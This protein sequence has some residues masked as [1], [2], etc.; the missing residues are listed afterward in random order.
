MKNWTLSGNSRTCGAW[1]RKH[2]ALSLPPGDAKNASSAARKAGEWIDRDKGEVSH[3]S[4]TRSW[5][6]L[7]LLEFGKALSIVTGALPSCCANSRSPHRCD[8]APPSTT[9]LATTIDR[10]ALC[11]TLRIPCLIRES[12][13]GRSAYGAAC[14]HRES[15][16]RSPVLCRLGAARDICLSGPAQPWGSRCSSTPPPRKRGSRQPGPRTRTA[17]SSYYRL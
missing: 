3:S 17:P 2:S 1:Q 14:T 11:S 4:K 12:S 13:P 5:Q 15:S 16:W 9:T 8:A 6:R 10:P 7:H